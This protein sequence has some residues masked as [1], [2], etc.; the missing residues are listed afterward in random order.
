MATLAVA[1]TAQA[2]PRYAAPNGSGPKA[3]CPQATPCSLK[4]AVEG[5][6]TGDE[7]IVTGGTYMLGSAIVSPE[8]SNVDIHG[9]FGGAMPR[10]TASMPGPVLPVY[11]TGSRVRYL[12][13]VNEAPEFAGGIFCHIGVTVERVISIVGGKNATALRPQNSCTVRDSLALAS[14]QEA[15]ALRAAGFFPGYTGVV[16]NVTA[17]VSGLES[18][19]VT[20]SYESG[21]AETGSY[22]LDFRNSIA[23]GP[24][25]DITATSTLLGPGNVVVASSN[26]DKA[27]ATGTATIFDAG[28]NQTTPPLFVNAAGGDYREAAGSPTID[29]GV[30]DAQI[31]SLDLAGN[32]RSLG[33]TP[34]IGA[35][36]VVP[37][38]ISSPP[39]APGQIQS[40]SVTPR[41]FRAAR[42][43]EAILSAKKRAK[44]PV[45]ATVDY[46][47]TAAGTMT[48][49]LERRLPGRKLGKRCVAQTKS[50]RSKKRCSRFKQVNGGFT[51]SGQAGQN[52]FKFSGRIGVKA[53]AP[54]SY[55][56]TGRTSAAF[57]TANFR[58][59][60]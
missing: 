52:R 54:G 37:P 41:K 27:V 33:A 18:T 22:T 3:E 8:G 19:S 6:D 16:R 60:K 21:K 31:G 59:V 20:A 26:F 10:V 1:A 38:A 47:L 42:A 29:A 17:L 58:I 4:D 50:N 14:G 7:V 55:R 43:G 48:F 36:E 30:A 35:F 40:L 23:A 28:G 51:H 12:E 44:A 45:G 13:V 15:V 56:L 39:P 46:S 32:P 5:A 2:A 49:S 9:D 11:T 34:D 57:K 24:G 53:L 25:P